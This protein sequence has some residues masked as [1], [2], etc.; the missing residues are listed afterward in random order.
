M[1]QTSASIQRYANK[2]NKIIIFN[3]AALYHMV[4]IKSQLHGRQG[5]Y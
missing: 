5:M 1:Y 4:S 3:V 2:F